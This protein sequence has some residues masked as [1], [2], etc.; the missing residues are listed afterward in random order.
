M[1]PR[2]SASK[3]GAAV[4]FTYHRELLQFEHRLTTVGAIADSIE[5]RM[6]ISTLQARLQHTTERLA[7]DRANVQGI[8]EVLN[9]GRGRNRR[10]KRRESI[11]NQRNVRG[12]EES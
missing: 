4:L 9:A 5:G 10:G 11:K 1:Q 7:R 3:I 2:L 12:V 6:Q 8:W